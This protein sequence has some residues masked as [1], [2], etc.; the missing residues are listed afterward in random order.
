MLDF[1]VHTGDVYVRHSEE[2][3]E[4]AYDIDYLKSM[5][6]ETGF[7]VRDIYDDLSFEPPKENSERVFFVCK[8]E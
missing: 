5:L 8:K 2:F 1:F 6:E 7:S 3:F 4:K